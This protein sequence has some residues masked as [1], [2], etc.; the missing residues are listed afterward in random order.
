MSALR[1]YSPN[2]LI[3]DLILEYNIASV[4]EQIEQMSKTPLLTQA[5]V[6]LQLNAERCSSGMTRLLRIVG[7]TGAG[8]SSVRPRCCARKVA[9]GSDG[10]FPY[11]TPDS[12]ST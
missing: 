12:R 1:Y 3:T 4:Y 10:E 8:G 7:E 11:G 6:R 2:L 9:L 5:V